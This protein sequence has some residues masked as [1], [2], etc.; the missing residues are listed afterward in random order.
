VINNEIIEKRNVG[1]NKYQL[2]FKNYDYNNSHGLILLIARVRNY[3]TYQNFQFFYQSSLKQIF[4]F[5]YD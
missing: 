3:V 1:G 2:L 4:K 5:N